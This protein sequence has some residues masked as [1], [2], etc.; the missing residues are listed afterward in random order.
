MKNN[1]WKNEISFSKSG[2]I[3]PIFMFLIFAAVTVWLY[4]IN[5]GAFFVTSIFSAIILLLLIVSTYRTLFVKILIGEN[6]FYHQTGINKG[7]EYEY[8]EIAEAWESSGKNP[9]DT[10]SHYFNY[11]TADGTVYKFLFYNYQYD[12]VDYLLE[13]INGEKTESNE[14]Y[15]GL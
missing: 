15:L 10:N 14:W 3:P 5:N 8:S 2:L 4:K 1:N 6:S 13:K 7:H 12:E 9:N 11:K